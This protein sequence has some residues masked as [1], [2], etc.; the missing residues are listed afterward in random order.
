MLTPTLDRTEDGYSAFWYPTTND[1]VGRGWDAFFENDT[2][3]SDYYRSVVLV[4]HR[5]A[6]VC[7]IGQWRQYVV[8]LARYQTLGRV[9]L[10]MPHAGIPHLCQWNDVHTQDKWTKMERR[11][12]ALLTLVASV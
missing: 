5:D 9:A 12:S 3:A 8:L 10:N 11:G 1:T 2:V 4:R 6:K 7:Y